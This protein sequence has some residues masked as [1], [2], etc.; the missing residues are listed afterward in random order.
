MNRIENP[1]KISKGN[2]KLGKV[3]NVS[4]SPVIGCMS[5]IQC[6]KSCYAMK[7][8]RQYPA[9]RAAWDYNLAIRTGSV[10]AFY[11]NIGEQIEAAKKKP[12]L[13]RFY[14]AGDITGPEDM[15]YITAMAECFKDTEFLIYTKNH[16]GV[17]WFFENSGPLP[18][19]LAVYFSTW[20]G[21]ETINPYEMPLAVYVPKGEK[22]PDGGFICPGHC[23]KCRYCFDE[24][25]DVY[26][27][28]H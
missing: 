16:K 13:F 11:H 28:H 24:K 10:F 19:N 25:T 27:P 26:F 22:V 1:V 8:Y 18:I 4:V 7:A 20:P 14:V 2:S 21:V 17:N 12:E 5:G 3:W 15:H 6:A 9:T 23:D